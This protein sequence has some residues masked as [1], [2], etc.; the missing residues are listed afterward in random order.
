MKKNYSSPQVRT[1]TILPAQMLATSISYGK[2]NT[3]VDITSNFN[4]N[5][6]NTFWS[7]SYNGSLQDDEVASWMS[8]KN[9]Y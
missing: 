5:S 2:T 4:Q 3:D 1:F 6:G 9:Q 7:N 8:K